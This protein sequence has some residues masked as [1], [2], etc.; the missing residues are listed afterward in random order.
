MISHISIYLIHRRDVKHMRLSLCN[1]SE[2]DR[3]I[4]YSTSVW[5]DYNYT[6]I[7]FSTSFAMANEQIQLLYILYS[8]NSC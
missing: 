2:L 7:Q 3:I 1:L 4:T 8:S 6:H 5:F